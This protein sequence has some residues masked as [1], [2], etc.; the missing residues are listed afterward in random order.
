MS[1]EKQAEGWHR[2]Y[3]QRHLDGLAP[4]NRVGLKERIKYKIAAIIAAAIFVFT[5]WLIKREMR[6]AMKDL[7]KQDQQ[8]ER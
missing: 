5:V 1:D 7:P 3:T 8:K 4:A 2:Q 6:K